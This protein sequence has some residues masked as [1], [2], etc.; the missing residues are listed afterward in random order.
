LQ[1]IAEYPLQAKSPSLILA[2]E[3]RMQGGKGE[4]SQGIKY[5]IS[6]AGIMK[7]GKIFHK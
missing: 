2:S 5:M 4:C 6:D 3:Q 1:N 7:K